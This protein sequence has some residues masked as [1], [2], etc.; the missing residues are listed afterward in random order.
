MHSQ[1]KQQLLVIQLI[2]FAWICVPYRIGKKQKPSCLHSGLLCHHSLPL[3]I[4]CPLSKCLLQLLLETYFSRGFR[5]RSLHGSE[6]ET[7]HSPQ[8]MLHPLCLDLEHKPSSYDYISKS[9][10]PTNKSVNVNHI[11]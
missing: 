11:L 1:I 8:P 6:R 4:Q 3:S 10:R 5:T 2:P 7:H 9:N